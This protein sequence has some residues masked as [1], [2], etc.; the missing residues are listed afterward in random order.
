MSQ[1]TTHIIGAGLAGLS[2]ATRLAE[3]GRQVVVYEAAAQAGGRCR[4]YYDTAFGDTIDNGNHLLLS[5]NE[6]A[7]NYLRRI[8]ARTPK[9]MG[10]PEF[11]FINV[12]TGKRWSV[13]AT[14]KTLPRWLF[15]KNYRG[16]FDQIMVSALNT[17]PREA[18]MRLLGAIIFGTIL[19][20]SKACIPIVAEGLSAV[21]VDPALRY[22]A[23]S[24]TG[25]KFQH[26]LRNILFEDG[27]AVALNFG[28]GDIVDINQNDTVICAIPP[29][30]AVSLLPGISAPDEYRAILNA[31]FRI[32]PPAQLGRI[33]GVV[34][35]TT[36]W[37][38]AFP[39]RISITVSDADRLM[40]EDREVLAKRLW[41]EISTITGLA[42]ALPAW[43][44][45]KEKRATFAATP[46]QDAKRPD[47]RTS[48]NNLYLA[49]DWV[50][51]GLPSTIE[52]AVLSGERAANLVLE[53]A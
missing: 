26:R 5:G 35:G 27:M 36:E 37:I 49:G 44:I 2:A 1:G 47:T 42:S 46:R 48:W 25:V 51:T 32:T 45:V 52:G 53:K 16:V 20:G 33:T 9:G 13:Y 22:L 41:A 40:Q 14:Y 23:A 8:R 30:V 29:W 38:F 21:L 3:A 43:Q 19:K 34:G 50:Q 7:L 28:D 18:S 24:N 15:D 39:D 6:A 12:A 11:P 10:I 17:S 4:S 31:H